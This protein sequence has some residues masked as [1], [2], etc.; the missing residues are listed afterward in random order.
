[1]HPQQINILSPQP[2]QTSLNS[3]LQIL[4]RISREITPHTIA[5][6]RRTSKLGRQNDLIAVAALSHPLA[7]PALRLAELIHVGRVDE[8]TAL[9]VEVIEDFKGG[10]PVAYSHELRPGVAE[11]HRS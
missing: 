8:I 4:P 2:L 6:P 7:D 9:L 5:K 11:V 10:G 1:M 3:Q